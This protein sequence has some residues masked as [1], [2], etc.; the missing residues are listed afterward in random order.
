M[1]ESNLDKMRDKVNKIRGEVNQE[2]KSCAF[3]D[4][5]NEKME[6]QLLEHMS[7]EKLE[8]LMGKSLDELLSYDKS[9]ANRPTK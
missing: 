2:S 4:R 7:V 3:L 8:H 5:E 1:Q 6:K 9:I